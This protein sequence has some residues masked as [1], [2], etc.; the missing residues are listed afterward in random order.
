MDALHKLV[1]FGYA[2]GA[3]APHVTALAVATVL[4]GWAGAKIFRYQ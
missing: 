1:N 2:P 3:A 4:C